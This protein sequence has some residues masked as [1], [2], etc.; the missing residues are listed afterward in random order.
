[1]KIKTVKYKNFKYALPDEYITTDFTGAEAVVM[2][3]PNGY[4]KTTVFDAIE[5]LIMGKIKHFNADLPN[6]RKDNVSVLANDDS[7]DISIVIDFINQD[8][9]ITIE[10][11]F[12]SEEGFNSK[13]YYKN[14]IIDNDKLFNILG[15]NEN[16]F[17][18]G[19]YIS[20]I[21]CCDTIDG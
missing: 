3:G 4:G 11:K 19:T 16:L 21:D 18:V 20:Q 17:S 12:I 15:I 1:M 7:S 8:E 6:N 5:L 10:R 2:G 9:I 14:Q 13:I